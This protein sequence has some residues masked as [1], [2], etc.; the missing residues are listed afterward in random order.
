MTSQPWI[1]RSRRRGRKG[2]TRFNGAMTSQPWILDRSKSRYW[3]KMTLQW[4]HDLSA[5]DTVSYRISAR[6]IVSLQ[7]SHDLSAM[8]T[9]SGMMASRSLLDGFNGAMTSQPWI[10]RRAGRNAPPAGRLQWSHDLSAMDTTDHVE[11]QIEPTLL[12][13]SHDLSAMDTTSTHRSGRYGLRLQWSHDLSAMDTR[14]KMTT[15]DAKFSLQ[16]SHDLSAMDTAPD[17]SI[18]MDPYAASMEP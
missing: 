14:R 4:S 13:W 11:T 18:N 8:D 1:P 12:Q 10:R 6:S 16:W 9:R 7:W 5:M 17:G 2:R 3:D 15:I